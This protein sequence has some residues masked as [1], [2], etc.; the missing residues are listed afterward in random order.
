MSEKSSKLLRK[1]AKTIGVNANR[2][3]K[4]YR[5]K[6]SLQRGKINRDFKRSLRLP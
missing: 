6:T 3:K 5:G 1:I 2:L 4:G